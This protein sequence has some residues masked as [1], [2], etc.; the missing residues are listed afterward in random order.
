M[1]KGCQVSKACFY[2]SSVSVACAAGSVPAGGR[3][4]WLVVVGVGEDQTLRGRGGGW[5][6]SSTHRL[7][8]Q[9]GEVQ[10]TTETVKSIRKWT[11]SR[12]LSGTRSKLTLGCITWADFLNTGN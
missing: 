4:W 12:K 11:P 2:Q 9:R 8:Q 7:L 3:L 10:T 6:S 1:K 5:F